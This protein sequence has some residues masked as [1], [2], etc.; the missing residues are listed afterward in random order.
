[1]TCEKIQERFADYLTGDLDETGRGAVREHILACPAC[2]ED[3]EDLTV[4]WAKLG[5]L[6]EEQPGG[7]LRH[8]FYTMLEEY[9]DGLDAERRAARRGGRAGWRDWFSFRHPAFAASFSAF[10]LLVGLAAGWLASGRGLGGARY[11]ELTREVQEVRQQYAL[12]LLGQPSATERIQGVGYTA[13]VENPS[14]TTLAALFKAV[15]TD[16]NPNVRLAAVDA[17]YLFRDR[18]G[19]RESLVKSLAVQTYPLVQVA[20]IDFLVEV[21]EARAAD[22][23]K[24][25]IE[26]GDL[27]P[28]V[29]QRAE[30]GLKQIGI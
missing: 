4:V 26:D 21:R 18:P 8:R 1:M 15:D 25:L 10:I 27:T 19:V 16:P 14:A 13:E 24:T 20:L 28:E 5:V 29:Q 2:R 23:L 11:A 7:G 30:Q 9:K 12:S 22:A 17:L 6:P 3:L